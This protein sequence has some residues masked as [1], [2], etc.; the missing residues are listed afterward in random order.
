ML[1]FFVVIVINRWNMRR[2]SMVSAVQSM[3]SE[4]P[5]TPAGA[6]RSSQLTSQQQPL[7]MSALRTPSSM[8]TAAAGAKAPTALPSV[9][10]T[11]PMAPPPLKQRP[12]LLPQQQ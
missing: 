6:V 5:Q 12:S 4:Q 3:E 7:T 2:N 9:S 8:P 11:T 1:L 10:T